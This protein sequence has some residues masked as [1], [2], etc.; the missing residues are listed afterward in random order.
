VREENP[1]GGPAAWCDGVGEDRADELGRGFLVLVVVGDA[2]EGAVGGHEER[3]VGLG[4]LE[5][6]LDVLVIVDQ[7]GKALGVFVFRDEL[8]NG[9]GTV[10]RVAVVIVSAVTSMVMMVIAVVVV[11]LCLGQSGL[12]IFDGVFEAASKS[13][14]AIALHYRVPPVVGDRL[15]VILVIGNDN[16]GL[17]SFR[18]PR[19]NESGGDASRE[20][21]QDLLH[22]CHESLSEAGNV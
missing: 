1:A 2:L 11:T 5:E 4:V 14:E 16:D 15:D 9:L 7:C 8:V 18:G 19:G 10:A 22:I 6:G 12:G 13:L 20:K 17:V 3:A 21:Q